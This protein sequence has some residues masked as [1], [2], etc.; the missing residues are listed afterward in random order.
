MKVRDARNTSDLDTRRVPMIVENLS[1]PADSGVWLEARAPREDG[2]QVCVICPKGRTRDATPCDLID[3]IH[4]YRYT[5]STTGTTSS[6]YVKESGLAMLKT[7]GLSFKLWRRHGFDVI[8]AANPPDTFFAIGLLYERFGKKY[9]LDEHDLAP[10]VLRV[11][12]PMRIKRLAL[13]S[14]FW[15]SAR[16]VLLTS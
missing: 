5:P 3:G 9:V 2:H 10:E 4:I 14:R 6:H 1:V 12:F 8:H 15:R 11:R 16:I 13:S 7:L